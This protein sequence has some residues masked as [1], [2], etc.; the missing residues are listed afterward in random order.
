MTEDVYVALVCTIFTTL[1]P[2]LIMASSFLIIGGWISIHSHD[3]ILIGLLAGATIAI[4]GR[5]A[6]L[7]MH[8][9][10]VQRPGF[11]GVRAGKLERRFAVFYLA[12]ALFFGLFAARAFAIGSVDERLLLVGLLFGYGAGV[13]AGISLRPW[14]GIPSAI[15]AIVPTIVTSLFLPGPGNWGVGLLTALFLAGGIESMLRRYQATSRQFALQNMLSTVDRRD[16][17]TGLPNRIGLRERFGQLIAPTPGAEMIALHCLEIDGVEAINHRLGYPTG[18]ALLK[19]VAE[20]LA[21][22]M[23]PG[24]FVVRLSGAEFGIVQSGLLQ[25][26]RAELLAH[27]AVDVVTRSYLMSGQDLRIS[28]HVGYALEIQQDADLDRLLNVAHHAANRARQEASRVVGDGRSKWASE[29][30]SWA[31]PGA[32]RAF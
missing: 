28:A 7:L 2:T 18:D 10:E 13:A 12:F 4:I 8:R 29:P 11:T 9:K 17:L 19:A 14:I 15:I 23:G 3:P 32:A 22:L 31:N 24:E 30:K 26:R 6:I 1:S 5:V 16:E 27:Q 20:R 21:R 25:P